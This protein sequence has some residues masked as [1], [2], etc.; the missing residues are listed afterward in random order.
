MTLTLRILARFGIAAS[1][2][3]LLWL[4]S[5]P[6]Q[7]ELLRRIG[8]ASE[9]LSGLAVL[10]VCWAVPISIVA[11]GLAWTPRTCYMVGALSFLFPALAL[12]GFSSAPS[13]RVVLL[14]PLALSGFVRRKLANPHLSEDE[15]TAAE[16]PPSIVPR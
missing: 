12:A 16:P 6:Y 1:F 7:T 15:A 9:V 4:L 13:S 10:V 2:A 5:A 14:F 11:R 8:F 3:G